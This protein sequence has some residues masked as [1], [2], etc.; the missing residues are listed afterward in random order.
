MYSRISLH[1][2]HLV[3]HYQGQRPQCT[4]QLQLYVWVPS[5]LPIPSHSDQWLYPKE[6]EN[7]RGEGGSNWG[8]EGLGKGWSRVGVAC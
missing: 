1:Q 5:N 3:L 6:S 4:S 8:R 2:V 7:P